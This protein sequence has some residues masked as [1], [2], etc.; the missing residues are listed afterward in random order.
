[1]E[2]TASSGHI[3]STEKR[4]N[5]MSDVDMIIG[6]AIKRKWSIACGESLT[7]GLVCA[8]LASVPGCSAV[9]RGGIVAYQ[10]EVKERAL[11]V[12]S[13]VLAQGLVSEEVA[14]ALATGARAALGA[15]IG[16]GTTGAAGPDP[17]DGA[18]PGSAWIAVS[19]PG[20]QPWTKELHIDGDREQVRAQVADAALALTALALTTEPRE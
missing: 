6:A 11:G 17:H 5:V 1:M 3:E 7:G 14:I 2:P 4:G 9:L 16:I 18:A 15:E 10:P 13:D 12:T 8:Q 19:V 20:G